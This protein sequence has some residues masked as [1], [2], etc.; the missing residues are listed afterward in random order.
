MSE[1]KVF[2]AGYIPDEQ[3][4]KDFGARR[5]ATAFHAKDEKHAAAKASFIFMEEYPGAQDAAYKHLLCEEAPGIPALLSISGMK[6]FYMNT[7][8]RKKLAIR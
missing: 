3:S 1:Q 7:T 6:I 2:I 5:V 8:G 4:V